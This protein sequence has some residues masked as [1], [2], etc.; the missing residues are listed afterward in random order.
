MTFSPSSVR[1]CWQPLAYSTQSAV[2]VFT[3]PEFS[4]SLALVPLVLPFP[5]FPVSFPQPYL[6]DRSLA[7]VTASS[8]LSGKSQRFHQ[9]LGGAHPEHGECSLTIPRVS[10]FSSPCGTPSASI[11]SSSWSP[12]AACLLPPWTVSSCLARDSGERAYKPLAKRASDR[13]AGGENGSHNLN[14]IAM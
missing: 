7:C 8:L 4:P 2:S 6:G 13:L 5:C 10:I 9:E 14:I 12:S 3:D 1:N 11:P